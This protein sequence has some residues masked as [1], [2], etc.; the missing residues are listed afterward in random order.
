M[1]RLAIKQTSV[2]KRE[3]C[4]RGAC[5]AILSPEGIRGPA[6]ICE[7][8]GKGGGDGLS[9]R[10][11][12]RGTVWPKVKNK[13]VA[14]P[15]RLAFGAVR[16]RQ[17]GTVKGETLLTYGINGKTPRQEITTW[18]QQTTS[19]HNNTSGPHSTSSLSASR[20]AAPLLLPIQQFFAHPHDSP[21]PPPAYS[22]PQSSPPRT[23]T[24]AWG[25][26]P[27]AGPSASD[28]PPTAPSAPRCAC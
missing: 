8:K 6:T 21:H 16:G 2:E 23:S 27:A 28:D 11:D 1:E 18:I 15:R 20:R 9:G 25:C 7:D 14:N 26:T 19:V 17:V 5:N 24:P 12:V 4:E 22:P 10:G 13:G 3:R